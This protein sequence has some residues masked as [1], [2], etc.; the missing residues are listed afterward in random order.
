[1]DYGR[2]LLDF[3]SIPGLSLRESILRHFWVKGVPD[4]D[5]QTVWKMLALSIMEQS[6]GVDPKLER[7]LS[8]ERAKDPDNIIDELTVDAIEK[9][10]LRT[11]PHMETDLEQDALRTL[12]QSF[13]TSNPSIGYC[14]SFSFIGAHIIRLFSSTNPKYQTRP[15]RLT[16]DSQLVMTALIRGLLPEQFYT[17]RM[18]SLIVDVAVFH[19]LVEMFLPRLHHHLNS[20]KEELEPSAFLAF[21][22]KWFSTLF[23]GLLSYGAVLR[24]WDSLLS[25]G[26]CMLF[27]TGL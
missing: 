11:T 25:C 1:V 19:D 5:R 10:V 20:I 23:T 27:V 7:S 24:L 26:E 6:R 17:G 16:K 21:V 14:Q 2:Q 22:S 4:R 12:L 18:E 3:T 9:D 8:K 13:A 15:E